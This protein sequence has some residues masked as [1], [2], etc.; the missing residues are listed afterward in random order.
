MPVWY[1][2]V[3]T[4]A[5]QYE[6]LIPVNHSTQAGIYLDVRIRL[7]LSRWW[8][9]QMTGSGWHNRELQFNFKPELPLARKPGR[10][11][12]LAS[13]VASEPPEA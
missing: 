11:R 13:E 7:V 10:R 5:R 8:R 1:M 2:L 9:F 6:N 12:Q 3:Y 4:G